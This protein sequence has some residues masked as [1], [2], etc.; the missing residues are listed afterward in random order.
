MRRI[1]RWFGWLWK[2]VDHI[3]NVQ[4]VWSAAGPFWKLLMLGSIAGLSIIGTAL[5]RAIISL[6]MW[7]QF[8]LFFALVVG[9]VG[10]VG[11]I[12]TSVLMPAGRRRIANRN[13]STAPA[14]VLTPQVGRRKH[15][16]RTSIHMMW[17][18]LE[19]TNTTSRLLRDVEVRITQMKRAFVLE[20]PAQHQPIYEQLFEP[21]RPAHLLW[22]ERN[23]LPNQHVMTIPAGVSRTLSVAYCDSET[24]VSA[25]LAIVNQTDSHRQH[26]FVDG[27]YVAIE[28]TSPDAP[29]LSAQYFLKCYK[30]SMVQ[31]ADNKLYPVEARFE[32]MEWDE[33]QKRQQRS[34]DQS[35]ASPPTNSE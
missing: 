18:E 1:G 20:N 33:H 4:F 28:V 22:S 5:I 30:P 16:P 11:Q 7:M 29:P 35:V 13:L 19:V 27:A 8:I 10:L 23:A 26:V 14:F 32:F 15:G 9:T 12:A 3:S 25:Y 34:P 24:N 31:M 21:V 2:T 6:P 17:A